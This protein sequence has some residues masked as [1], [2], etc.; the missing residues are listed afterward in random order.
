MDRIGLGAAL[1]L[2]AL[3]CGCGSSHIPQNRDAAAALA[4]APSTDIKTDCSR[5]Y[6]PAVAV[7]RQ[8]R[9]FVAAWREGGVAVSEDG[10]RTFAMRS[11][12]QPSSPTPAQAGGASDD[13]VNV[14]PWGTLYYT[15]LWA[16]LGG[17]A[18]AGV[19]FAASDD[20]GRNWTQN[21]FIQVRVQPSSL[22]I[23]SD[24][25]WLSFEGDATIHML[26]NCGDSVLACMITSHDRGQTWSAARSVVLPLAH[27]F[28]SPLGA[29]ADA[30]GIWLAPFYALPQLSPFGAR[31]IGVVSSR[32]GGHSFTTSTVYTHP[33]GEGTGGGGWP[34]DTILR[35]GSWVVGWATSD[36][37]LWLAASRDEG[38]SWSAPVVLGLDQSGNAGSPWLEARDDGGFDALWF[39]Y[40][41]SGPGVRLGRYRADLAL[42]S[43]AS[44]AEIGG[45][46]S[47]YPQ[48]AHLPD[49]RVVTAYLTPDGRLR[50]AVSNR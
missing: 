46:V 36:G 28:P 11:V 48:F 12:P 50:A 27:S 34:A 39:T 6:E 22:A 21:Q 31:S 41:S 43:L 32:D 8:G 16:D 14:A 5:C 26:F 18:G 13:I 35:D 37:R 25:Q 49:G 7:D 20:G 17:D 2:A 33:V 4:F 23:E 15:E 30:D 24:R 42:Q 29:P 9:I 19:H 1:L 44:V 38:R 10:G 45:D 40:G 47:D 3:S